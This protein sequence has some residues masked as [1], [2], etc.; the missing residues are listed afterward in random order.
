MKVRNKQIPDQHFHKKWMLNVK[1]RF[2][3]PAAK[4]RRRSTRAQKAV[5]IAPRPVA[6]LLRPAVHAPTQ[7]YNRKLRAGRGF[8]L[9]ELKEAGVRRKEA[10]S[11]G[12]AVDHRRRNRSLESLQ[13]NVNRLKTYRSKLIVFPRHHKK[14]KHG[15]SAAAEL[16][17]ATQSHAKEILS[18]SQPALRVKA[19]KLTDALQK[20]TAYATIRKARSDV[21]LAGKRAKRAAEREANDVAAAKKESKKAAKGDDGD[22]KKKKDKGAAAEEEAAE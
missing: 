20:A 17:T 14:P 10:R 22:K 4:H 2:D 18:I 19:V 11:I 3:Q 13:T 7:Q 9:D 15:D 16:V 1:T 12:I 5:R 8:T 6:G 21:R